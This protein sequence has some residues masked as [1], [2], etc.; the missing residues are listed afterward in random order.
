MPL[1]TGALG[2][3][4]RAR[5]RSSS[6]PLPIPGR[7]MT[8]VGCVIAV[9]TVIG[10]GRAEGLGWERL[11]G[12]VAAIIG[13][14]IVLFSARQG[15]DRERLVRSWIGLGF[16]AWTA[17]QFV[18]AFELGTPTLPAAEL[19][20]ALLAGV[21]AASLGG[22]WAVLHGRVSQPRGAGRL[23][24]CRHRRG[25]RRGAGPGAVPEQLG[26]RQLHRS[27]FTRRSFCQ[28]WRRPWSLT[29]QCCPSCG[30]GAPMQA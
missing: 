7:G 14:A 25:G 15:S 21:L 10:F 5:P 20:L 29:W 13:L 26:R 22:Y 24:G 6:F 23:P 8:V 12:P 19:S 28:S 17:S 18:T 27:P 1:A 3:A 9:L 30:Y 2:K 11:H 16:G 4:Q